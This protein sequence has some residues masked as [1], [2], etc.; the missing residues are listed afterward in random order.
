VKQA[1]LM[2]ASFCLL[3]LVVSGCLSR[4]SVRK[5]SKAGKLYEPVKPASLSEFIRAVYKIEREN[6]NKQ[7]EERAALL[8]QSPE[9]ADLSSRVERNPAD[10]DA[11]VRLA[12][13][14][15]DHQLYWGA[16]D[17]LTNAQGASPDD[18]AINLNFARVWDGWG[19]YDLALSYGERATA[20]G[21]ASAQAYEV[22]GRIHLH[23]NALPEAI[24]AFNQAAQRE[25]KPSILS[26]LG[27]SYILAGDWETARTTLEKAV[28]LDDAMA[29]AHNNLAI[30]LTKLGDEEGALR[31]LSKTGKPPV[32]MNNMGVLYLQEHKLDRARYFFK[33]AVR[34]EPTYEIGRQN[35]H[36]VELQMPPAAIEGN[37]T[38]AIQPQK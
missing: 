25:N 30:V 7:A 32:A 5:D 21:A 22:L 16:Y 35:L 27:Y 38:S 37:T 20:T 9:L 33:E 29:E 31:Q 28:E 19:E 18:P 10:K 15:I 3:G 11:A 24:A 8:A 26:N 17:L 12:V 1:R 13:A 2:L 14:Y 34:L 36:A 23:R 4:T 6:N